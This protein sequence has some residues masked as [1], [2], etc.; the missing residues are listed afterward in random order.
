MPNYLV[1][2]RN[3]TTLEP[4]LSERIGGQKRLENQRIRIIV[5]P[6]ALYFALI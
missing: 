6:V 4:R 1:I 2:K 3:V 5:A